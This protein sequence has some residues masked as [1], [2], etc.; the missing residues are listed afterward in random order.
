MRFAGDVA[1]EDLGFAGDVVLA[2]QVG[3]VPALLAA[4]VFLAEGRVA[5]ALQ[6]LEVEP[7]RRGVDPHIEVLGLEDG[8]LA[9]VAHGLGLGGEEEVLEHADAE[10]G[11]GL[12]ERGGLRPVVAG[13]DAV[14]DAE[15]RL[16]DEH[17]FED[18]LQLDLVLVA[19]AADVAAGGGDH[20]QQRLAA[21]A[22]AGPHGVVELGRAVLVVLVDDGAA[23]RR[24]I[25]RPADHG[26]EL[27]VGV[28]HDQAGDVGEHAV[29][30][31]EV[32]LGLRHQ[33]RRAEDFER[34]VAAGGAAADL[35]PVFAVGGEHV[36]A[37]DGGHGA[38]GVLARHEQIALCGSA[39]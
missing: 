18:L 39:A 15:A 7:R 27:A 29:V 28:E 1:A 3:A 10:V 19:R 33:A 5:A 23:G 14:D 12:D 4:E 16:V 35:G 9:R 36:V 25:A 37:D 22:H 30:G 32:G 6:G 31:A 2:R 24:A 20:Q 38:L 26:L 11:V 17:A 21:R 34:L 13:V 8:R